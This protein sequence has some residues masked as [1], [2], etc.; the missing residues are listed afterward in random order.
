MLLRERHHAD[1]HRTH[2][3]VPP[4]SRAENV[5]EPEYPRRC[6]AITARLVAG[7]SSTPGGIPGPSSSTRSMVC[8]RAAPGCSATLTATSSDTPINLS[9]REFAILSALMERP[10]IVRSKDDLE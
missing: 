7:L 5:S 9:R 2:A 4:S 10:E 6:S 8:V 1:C 3:L